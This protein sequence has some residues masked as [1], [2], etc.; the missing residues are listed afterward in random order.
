MAIGG[1]GGRIYSCKGKLTDVTML[2]GCIMQHF[3]DATVGNG[4]A[5]AVFKNGE[6][7][8]D[9]PGFMGVGHLRVSTNP[10]RF[11]HIK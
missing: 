6:R 2:F 7:L 11:L 9:L 5:Q 8:V 3:I 1:Q 10:P 4:M